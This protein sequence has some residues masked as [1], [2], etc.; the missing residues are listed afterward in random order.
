MSFASDDLLFQ[1]LALG[2]TM[3]KNRVVMAPMTRSRSQQPGNVPTALNAEYYAQRAGSGLIIS[4]GTQISPQGQ[5]Y[6]WTPGLH[7]A[8][9]IAGW[10]LVTDAVHQA[11]GRIFAQLWHVG[12]MSHPAVNGLQPVAPS[13]LLAEGGMVFIN[14]QHGPR[15]EAVP[16]PRALDEG[17]IRQTIADYAQAARNAVAAGFDGVELHG[18]NG[19]LIDQFLRSG[20]NQRTDGYGGSLSN[21]TR[22]VAEVAQ[23]CADA[24]GAGRVG[25]RLSPFL[26]VNGISDD[27]PHETFLAAATVLAE[28]GVSFIHLNE[29][30]MVGARGLAP[31]AFR[32]DLRKVY[33]GTVIV[34]GGYDGDSA[35]AALGNG[36]VDMVGFGRP[37]I[38]NPDLAERLRDGVALNSAADRTTYFGGGAAG[39]T[40]Y[41]RVMQA[42]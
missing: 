6:A 11:G 40:D 37:Y 25:I 17:E 2:E 36:L 5:G 39:Y 9:Q 29:E 20:S 15:M 24:I 27:S 8:E 1:P 19:Y 7:T 26:N 42:A 13:P 41:P 35:R 38:S 34:C 28:V 14:D 3:L 16:L 22:F 32:A 4:E 31:E 10:R 30:S 33:G 23:A 18:A 12:R 21:R